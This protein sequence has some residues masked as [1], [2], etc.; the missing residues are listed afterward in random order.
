MN[1]ANNPINVFA[2]VG[3]TTISAKFS[4]APIISNHAY[5]FSWASFARIATAI[6]E[7]VGL[8]GVE[9]LSAGT[10]TPGVAALGGVAIGLAATGVNA[11]IDAS[12]GSVSLL[13][14]GV[15]VATSFI[16]LGGSF[17]RE[18]RALTALEENVWQLEGLA[19]GAA[20]K[21][22]SSYNK[23]FY[24]RLIEST[25]RLSAQDQSKAVKLIQELAFDAET[26]EL[27]TEHSLARIMATR[28]I[29]KKALTSDIS[30]MTSLTAER[31]SFRTVKGMSERGTRIMREFVRD[32][33]TDEATLPWYKE[34]LDKSEHIND[35]IEK[36]SSGSFRET[37][38]NDVNFWLRNEGYITN[39]LKQIAP[40]LD[41]ATLM[42]LTKKSGFRK[43]NPLKVEKSKNQRA[44]NE[45]SAYLESRGQT[46]IYKDASTI[47]AKE[48][49]ALWDLD[50]S[51][52]TEDDIFATKSKIFQLLTQSA[53][54]VDRK[55]WNSM[56]EKF[57]VLLDGR[58]RNII[59]LKL[60]KIFGRNGNMTMDRLPEVIFKAYSIDQRMTV[61]GAIRYLGSAKFNRRW[62]QKLQF[63]ADPNDA[64]RYFV[65]ESYQKASAWVNKKLA[66]RK[67]WSSKTSGSAAER[68]SVDRSQGILNQVGR[69]A[70]GT[71]LSKL[72]RMQQAFIKGG[73]ALWPYNRYII[74]HKVILESKV[75][76]GDHLVLIKFNKAN[77]APKGDFTAISDHNNSVYK[78]G[79]AKVGGTYQRPNIAYRNIGG[80]RDIM[81]LASSKDLERFSI[82]GTSYWFAVGKKRGWFVSRGGKRAA[83]GS[84]SVSD[85]LALFLGFA[86]IGAM[87]NVGSIVTNW[88]ENV[89]SLAKGHYTDTYLKK[90]VGSFESTLFNRTGR[91]L[92]RGVLGG[93]AKN[94]ARDAK[95][96]MAF[97]GR[98]APRELQRMA[99]I[100]THSVAGKNARGEFKFG[101]KSG[102]T[103][104]RTAGLGVGAALRSAGMRVAKSDNYVDKLGNVIGSPSGRPSRQSSYTSQLNSTARKFGVIRRLPGTITPNDIFNPRSAGR[105]KLK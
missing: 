26:G 20:G 80:K 47:S 88:V 30:S 84:K 28:F 38:R 55:I 70:D 52:V 102:A 98:N 12:Q 32:S 8:I 89:N 48:E 61:R 11:V 45:V 74:G 63:I 50:F 59:N 72:G 68:M 65:E 69:A 75:P 37:Y 31:S 51:G 103:V 17:F 95:G 1:V 71:P 101:V 14:L 3:S 86:P 66:F 44:L 6:A 82:E 7:V 83:R 100:F 77:T 21:A 5:H 67:T 19:T 35:L 92:S 39:K 29:A 87:K 36:V 105:I 78:K 4:D 93:I 57:V 41:D 22:N 25:D 13:N 96:F 60:A 42:R 76:M 64:G 94:A 56:Y 49:G 97:V 16:P 27:T 73:G 46:A 23:A 90:W 91:L 15:G 9:I 79:G 10:A 34:L 54:Y 53:G 58:D 24:R 104:L 81:I 43:I 18:A 85:N 99:S 62:V 2:S 40:E 33:L